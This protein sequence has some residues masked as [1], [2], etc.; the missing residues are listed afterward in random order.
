MS[1]N[2]NFTGNLIKEARENY[3]YTTEECAEKLGISTRYLQKIENEGNLPSYGTLR[4]IV[5]L[6]SMDANYLF[7]DN[8]NKDDFLRSNV[9]QKIKLCD[10]YELNVI[11]ATLNAL[12][13]K[14]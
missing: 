6:F 8:Y 2:T 12:L 11:S 13:D 9:I 1:K 7:Y 5:Q 3:K 14:K 10:D 4:N